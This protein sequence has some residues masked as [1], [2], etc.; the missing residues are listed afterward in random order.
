MRAKKTFDEAQGFPGT[1]FDVS[2]PDGRGGQGNQGLTPLREQ[3]APASW[4]T[5]PGEGNTV[6][7]TKNADYEDQP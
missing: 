4:S 3:A 6:G 5:D 1:S 7:V 2:T